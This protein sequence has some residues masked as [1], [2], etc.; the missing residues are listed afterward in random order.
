MPLQSSL[1][2][3]S[4]TI[5]AVWLTIFMWNKYNI[6]HESKAQWCMN[7]MISLTYT[8]LIGKILLDLTK[9]E[10]SLPNRLATIKNV[11]YLEDI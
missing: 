4:Y 10:D 9:N 5:V 2:F 8:L 3:T 1:G 7:G 11:W 6:I